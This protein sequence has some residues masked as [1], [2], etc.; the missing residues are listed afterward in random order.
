MVFFDERYTSVEA[1][2]TLQQANLTS[3]RRK[4]RRDMI[5]AQLMLAAY[6]ESPAAWLGPPGGL[7]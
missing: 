6:L 4:K 7:E 1:E 2:R 5:A 3:K